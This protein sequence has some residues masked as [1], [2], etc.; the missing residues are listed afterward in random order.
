MQEFLTDLVRTSL[1]TPRVAARRV[2]ALQLDLSTLLM[3][4]VLVTVG[5]TLLFSLSLALV[6]P[7]ADLPGLFAN[8]LL[9][10]AV[11][12]A[13]VLGFTALLTRIGAG[14]GGTGRLPEVMAVSVWLQ[15]LRLL[16]QLAIV[17]AT[18]VLPPIAV[19]LTLVVTVF[20]LWLFI[21]FLQEAHGF[22]G[23]MKALVTAGL[24][25]LGLSVGVALLLT[26]IGV[27]PPATI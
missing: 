24:S 6:P 9:Y 27:S 21:S 23:P 16:A 13:G 10:A 8:P 11:M 17:A 2:I 1:T 7:V 20:G 15:F 25:V 22:Q 12:V 3:L 19:I 4:L 26:L 18:L 5:N 14:L